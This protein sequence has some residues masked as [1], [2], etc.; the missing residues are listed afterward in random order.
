MTIVVKV[1]AKQWG[2][3]LRQLGARMV[4][5][6]RR[7]A[8]AAAYRA[9]AQLQRETSQD[10]L[11]NTANYKRSWRA[12]RTELGAVVAN[13]APYA[14]VIEEGR[15]AG[16]RQPPTEYIKRWAQRRLGL[17]E[18]EAAAA[19]FP[20]ARAIAKKGLKPRRVLQSA[21]PEIRRFV[22]EE[23]KRELDAELRRTP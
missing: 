4:P 20:I 22:L 21:R 8:L 14:A 23:I 6:A 17:S 18:A 16:S 12:D 9:V 10:N 15:R 3:Y 1:S 11:V 5:A 13:Q 2:N 7:G 19:A